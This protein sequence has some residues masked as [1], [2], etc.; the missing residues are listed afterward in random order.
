L[1][2]ASGNSELISASNHLPIG[3]VLSP[4]K[5]TALRLRWRSRESAITN[6]AQFKR[7]EARASS[8]EA[9]ISQRGAS[10]FI[11]KASTKRQF[12]P[13]PDTASLEQPRTQH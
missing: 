11:D 8:S 10:R 12:A 6:W 7:I 2:I 9:G 4:S 3:Y 1:E 13:Q 5:N